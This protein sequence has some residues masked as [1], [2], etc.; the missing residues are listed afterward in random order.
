MA[1]NGEGGRPDLRIVFAGDIM[2][3]DSQIQAAFVDST[4]DYDYGECYRL[5]EPYLRDADIA[6]GNLEVTLAGPPYRG[7]PRFSSPDA[8][9][10][11]LI[12]AG[13]HV[14]VNANNHVLD[15]GSDGFTRTQEVVREKGLFMTGSFLSAG[16]R[17][18]SYPLLM[19][20]NGILLGLLN[21][22]YGTNGLK[23]DSEQVV[24]YID[25]VQIRR[26][27]HKVLQAGPD[28]V[29]ACV[30]WGTEYEREENSSQQALA[31]F[32]FDI[33][34]DAIIGSHPHVVQPARFDTT[35]A[36][37]H[38]LVVYSLGNFISNQRDRYRDGGILF[39]LNLYKS[40]RTRMTGVDYL[41][42]WVHKPLVGGKHVF[43]LIPAHM[44]EA[45]YD[46]LGLSKDEIASCRQFYEDTRD[47]LSDIPI[48]C[49]DV[50]NCSR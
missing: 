1:Q 18:L 38:R 13:F 12:E 23:T 4:G 25:T 24:N 28:F 44:E 37:F 22:T 42:F 21:F 19:E 39:G 50:S 2:G 32:L 47:H 30:H 20:K 6:V 17:E 3:H 35:D 10:D 48:M 33:G 11:A 16:H 31:G 41:P 43:R 27:M 49:L 15:R 36:S 5:L 40:E 45:A 34:V 14:I 7:Y 9:A 29:I 8:L 46:S 26:D